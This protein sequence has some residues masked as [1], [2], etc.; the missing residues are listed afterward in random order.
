M[1][2]L[3]ACWLGARTVSRVWGFFFQNAVT[4][5]LEQERW[6][7]C[8]RHLLGLPLCLSLG[9]EWPKKEHIPLCHRAAV[10]EAKTSG[11]ALQPWSALGATGTGWVGA[12]WLRLLFQ[13][14]ALQSCSLA[15]ALGLK[16]RT[17]ATH[18]PLPHLAPGELSLLQAKGN[19]PQK[20]GRLAHLLL[21]A[22]S[23]CSRRRLYWAFSWNT[24]L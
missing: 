5:K 6:L 10:A 12:A 20:A 11:E 9:R 15:C 4:E 22:R 8:V 14:G 21:I 2:A 17:G 3:P 16:G 13:W 18:C 7:G 19:M 23:L 1:V 24:W